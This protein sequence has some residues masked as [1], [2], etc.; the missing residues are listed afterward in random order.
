CSNV[1]PP[2]QVVG[3]HAFGHIYTGPIGLIMTAMHHGLENAAGPQSPCA[4]CNACEVVCPAE[5]PIPRMILDVR[6][7]VTE[8]FGLPRVKDFALG[9]WANPASGRRMLGAAALGA[10]LVAD[11]GVIRS[12]P[13]MKGATKGRALTAPA[14]KP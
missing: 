1:C 10:R 9:K 3:G 2:Y 4:S 14:R 7:R 12:A 6:S 8:E 11:D 13:F 5:I